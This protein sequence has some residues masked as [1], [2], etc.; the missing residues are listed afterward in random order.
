MPKFNV[1]LY[2]EVRVLVR[3]VEA[4]S[5][6]DAPGKAEDMVDL[7]AIFNRGDVQWTEGAPTGFV[8]DPLNADGSVDYDH[9]ITVEGYD[10]RH[11][12][13]T[14]RG[15]GGHFIGAS[16]CLFRRNTL[17]TLKDGCD[18]LRR[19]VVSS[20]GLWRVPTMNEGRFAELARGRY[21][22]TLAF[23]ADGTDTRYFDA[24][25]DRPVPFDS[26]WSIAE[27]DADDRANAM[28]EAVVAEL[29]GKLIAGTLPETKAAPRSDED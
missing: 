25:I 7:G 21:F 8:I 19:I 6:K 5:V 28:H 9:S 23:E 10:A 12:D 11:V 26:P 17:L 1:H 3:D 29:T 20:V 4:A 2:T 22:E 14:E 16:K 13:R 15:W 27:V 18:V 24:D